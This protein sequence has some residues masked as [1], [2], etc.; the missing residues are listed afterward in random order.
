MVTA[1]QVCFTPR[2]LL[3][4]LVYALLLPLKTHTFTLLGAVI[5]YTQ[6][7]IMY[8]YMSVKTFVFQ[9]CL[10]CA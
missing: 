10:S 8:N 7:Y 1:P 5:L 6:V 4:A 9:F 2:I 3:P